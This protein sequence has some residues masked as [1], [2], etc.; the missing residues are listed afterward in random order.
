[1]LKTALRYSHDL[2]AEII[3]EGDVV[4]DGTVGNGHDTL[5]LAELVGATGYVYGYDIQAQGLVNTQEKLTA[6]NLTARVTLFNQ[7]HETIEQTIP[8]ETPIKA[9][10]F[11]LGYLPKSNKKIITTSPTTIQ[12]L[13]A[14]LTRLVP[15]G[16]IIVVVY[17]GHDG[18]LA[19]KEGVLAF[20][21]S[22]P[23]EDFNVLSYQFINQRNTPPILIAI[24]KK[25]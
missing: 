14:L 5:F 11:N 18:G 19:E 1:M 20:V 24:E 15:C 21:E 2:L 10:I 12:A 3:T 6:A 8:V 4:V 17:Y 23:Q 25:A 7:G 9:G 16:R 13:Q 22:I